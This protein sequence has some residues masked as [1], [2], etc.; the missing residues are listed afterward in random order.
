MDTIREWGR[1]AGWTL[2]DGI[3]DGVHCFDSSVTR[4][5]HLFIDCCL[6]MHAWV[7]QHHETI[8][9]GRNV[10]D[11]IMGVFL[12]LVVLILAR[13]WREERLKKKSE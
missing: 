9:L 4:F 5:Y 12:L 11:G 1:S 3:D 6:W 10:V 13:H 7:W 8:A 2:Y